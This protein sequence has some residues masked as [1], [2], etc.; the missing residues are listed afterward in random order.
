[1]AKPS[2]EEVHA[3]VVSG[4]VTDIPAVCRLVREALGLTITEYA[5]VVGLNA[6]YLG[7]IERGHRDNPTLKVLNK[8][9]APAGLQAG[10]IARQE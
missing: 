10:L 5:Q 7:D 4:E 6:R 1:M 9:V 8:I 2:I 3:K